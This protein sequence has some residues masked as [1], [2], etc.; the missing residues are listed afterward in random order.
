MEMAVANITKRGDSV[1]VCAHGFFGERFIDICTRKGLEVDVLKAAW[2][3]VYTPEQLDA[4]LSKKKYTAVTV[5]HVDTSTGVVA[6][7]KAIC[8]MMKAKHPEVLLIVDGVAA[9]GGEEEWS[10]WGIDVLFTGTQKAFGV[11]PGLAMLWTSARAIEKRASMETIPESY[12]DFQKWIPVMNDPSKYWATPAVNLVWALKE[13]VR[14]MKEEGLEERYARHSRQAAMFAAAMEALGFR[15]AA[16]KENRASTLSVFLYPEGSGLED[17]PFRTK[18]AEEGVQG[19][20][21]L[22]DFLGKGFRL[23][24]MGNIDKHILVGTI[25]SVERACIKCGYKIEP[26]KGLGV[27]QAGLVNE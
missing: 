7:V 3:T 14:I 5:T 21:C 24:H 9:T 8:D 26:G 1:L 13:S 17:M 2:G 15:I 6:P 22:G 19:A 12:F 20:G 18:L 23:G 16:A 11:A 25:A 4:E 27:L 10:D